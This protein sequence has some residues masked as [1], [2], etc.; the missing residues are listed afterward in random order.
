MTPTT[1]AQVFSSGGGTQ[2]CAIAA[3]IVQGRLPKPDICVIADTGYEN[4]RTWEYTD[5]IVAPALQD[6]GVE[7]C[8][9]LAADWA[10]L[11]GKGVFAT[12][13]QLMIPAYT[14]QSG[15]ISKLSTYCSNAWKQEV[16]DRWLSKACGLTRSQ[17]VKWIGFSRDEVK[18]VFRMAKGEEYLKGLIRFPLVRDVQTTRHE[19]IQIVADMGW[20]TPPRSRCWMCPNQNDHEWREIKAD[21]NMW[22]SAVAFEDAFR[23]RDPHAF[24]HKSGKPLREVDF[25]EED[26]LFAGKCESGGCFL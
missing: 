7:V 13:G 3:L 4:H 26:D 21:V 15:V 14:D 2:S 18:R 9:I 23:L 22:A 12:S 11:W 24:C 6:C 5:A 19:A 17:F 10:S 25:T 1:K 8:R 16:V 20:P